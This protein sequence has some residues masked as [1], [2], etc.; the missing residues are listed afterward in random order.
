MSNN[1]KSRWKD[2]ERFVAKE[3]KG[4]RNIR[5]DFSISAPDIIFEEDFLANLKVD[6]KKRKKFMHHNLIGEI[7]K[8]YCKNKKDIPIL[9]TKETRGR[10]FTIAS[11]P[12]DYF[13]EMFFMYKKNLKSSAKK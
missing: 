3:L 6:C 9:I 10:K 2:F 7:E 5:V 1:N 13:K 11:I 4:K 12:F 8:K